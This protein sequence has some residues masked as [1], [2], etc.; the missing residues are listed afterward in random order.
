MSSE[1]SK[2][3]EFKDEATGLTIFAQPYQF[4][5]EMMS[6]ISAFTLTFDIKLK[7]KG[8]QFILLIVSLGK[9][10]RGCSTKCF[11]ESA[12][13]SFGI[14]P[15]DK[16]KS[17]GMVVL[18]PRFEDILNHKND[19]STKRYLE[20][21]AKQ[22]TGENFR[23]Y[24]EKWCSQSKIPALALSA[25]RRLDM[26]PEDVIISESENVVFITVPKGV[27][28]KLDDSEAYQIISRFEP[29]TGKKL[30]FTVDG[31]L[32]IYTYRSY[33]N[34]MLKFID[35]DLCKNVNA[36]EIKIQNP[37]PVITLDDR[38]KN[39]LNL[40]LFQLI[41]DLKIT[42]GKYNGYWNSTHFERDMSVPYSQ[43]PLVLNPC[44]RKPL[45]ITIKDAN[46]KNA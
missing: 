10:F 14:D 40:S 3:T 2:M 8:S 45:K 27:T 5:D 20:M 9:L 31:T 16:T 41:G 11:P 38:E 4:S 35:H 42:I 6:E 21:L 37:Q 23:E 46:L 13:G 12:V 26:K 39:P 25:L 7:V 43:P 29:E 28:L 32:V 34:A 19:K 24:I 33:S 1:Q 44:F 17:H 36:L 18:P 15:L 22:A 30:F